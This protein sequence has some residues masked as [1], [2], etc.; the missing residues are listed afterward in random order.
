[1]KSIPRQP[2]FSKISVKN[3]TVIPI[4]VCERPNLQP[5]DILRKR[6]TEDGI[7]LDKAT[8]GVEPFATF[9]EWTSDA[10]EKAYGA[11]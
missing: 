6:A 2:M 9:S 3:Q 5:A 8:A 4:E 1:M 11:L 10:D 7:L